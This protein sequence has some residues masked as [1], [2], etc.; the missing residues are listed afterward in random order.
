MLQERLSK[1]LPQANDLS[2]TKAWLSER[3]CI[4]VGFKE[5][6]GT[7]MRGTLKQP[8]QDFLLP[9]F[10]A[11]EMTERVHRKMTSIGLSEVRFRGRQQKLLLSRSENNESA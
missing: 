3:E 6:H 2:K 8:H 5:W 10:N 9:A 4:K 7:E 11:W 1:D